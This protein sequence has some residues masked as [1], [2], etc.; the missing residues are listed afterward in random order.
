VNEADWIDSEDVLAMTRLLGVNVS[1]RKCRLF[2][3]AGSRATWSLLYDDTS[4]QS[5]EVA[6]RFADGQ[7]TSVE[8]WRAHYGAECPTF[9]HALLPSFWRQFHRNGSIPDDVREL[10][11]RGILDEVNLQRDSELANPHEWNRV[12]S[13]SRRAEYCSAKTVNLSDFEDS[14]LQRFSA[15]DEWPGAW[16]VR[17]IFGNPFRPVEFDP[18]WRTSDVVGLARAIY[19]DRAFERMPILADALMD[20]GCEHEEI[21]GHCRGDGPHV[22]GC[23]VVDLILGKE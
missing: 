20:A 4:R 23:W 3:C 2:W 17:D 11:A 18:R 9:G 14:Y 19:D 7:A 5:I 16:L 22:R 12:Q 1:A 8:L 6:E 21:I 10:V 15:L 13:A